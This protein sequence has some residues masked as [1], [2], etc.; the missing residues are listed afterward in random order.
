MD[1]ALGEYL[2][3]GGRNNKI[4]DECCIDAGEGHQCDTFVAGGK[5]AEEFAVNM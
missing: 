4:N 1:V 3:R 5:N 2:R